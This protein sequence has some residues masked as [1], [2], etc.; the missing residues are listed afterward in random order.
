MKLIAKEEGV[1]AL[2]NG[3]RA[4]LVL[5]SNPTIHFVVYDKVNSIMSKAA[6]EAGRKH[7]SAIEVFVAG[8]FLTQVASHDQRRDCK[9]CSN[10]YYIPHTTC[11]ISN[12]SKEGRSLR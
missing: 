7:L 4:S 2:W 5:V 9:G 12:E 3:V 6:E 1:G 11:S 8:L 10:S